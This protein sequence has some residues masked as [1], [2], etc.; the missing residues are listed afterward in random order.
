METVKVTRRIRFVSPISVGIIETFVSSVLHT[1]GYKFIINKYESERIL[2]IYPHHDD[3]DKTHLMMRESKFQI[4]IPWIY[5]TDGDLCELINHIEILTYR[6][7]EVALT[8][9][10]KDQI[11]FRWEAWQKPAIKKIQR[12]K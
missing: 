10:I 2:S 4:S 12:K 6:D 11:I 3:E 9:E 5:R 8:K 1:R 7:E